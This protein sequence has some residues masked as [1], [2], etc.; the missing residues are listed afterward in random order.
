MSTGEQR[1]RKTASE[2]Q[3]YQLHVQ[4]LGGY[5]DRGEREPEFIELQVMQTL[6]H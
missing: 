6:F 3:R 4:E 5:M 2:K 1:Q